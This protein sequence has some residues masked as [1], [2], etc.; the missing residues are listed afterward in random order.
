MK[1][2]KEAEIKKLEEA[3]RKKRELFESIEAAL[4][5]SLKGGGETQSKGAKK[6]K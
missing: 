5:S 2:E 6:A 1:D 4:A 3:D